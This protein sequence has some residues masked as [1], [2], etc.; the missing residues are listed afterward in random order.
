MKKLIE[1]L[2]IMVGM[3]ILIYILFPNIMRV[4]IGQYGFLFVLVV[5]I[6]IIINSIPKRRIP[7]NQHE[8]PV[9]QLEYPDDEPEY[10]YLLRDDFLSLAEQSFY[11]TLKH[12]CSDWALICPKVALGNLFYVRSSDPSDFRTYTNKIDRKHVDF[13]L[14]DPI[15]AKPLLGIELDDKSHQRSEVM[16]R[17][18]FVENVYRSAK[19]PLV[20]IPVKHSYSTAELESLLRQYISS[21]DFETPGQPLI[22]EN[23]E[24][25][26]HCPKCGNGMVLRTAKNGPNQGEQFWGCPDYPRCRGVRKYQA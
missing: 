6:V 9:D 4:V 2:A 22:I 5:I 14:C 8:Y 20:R 23:I 17:D 10:P 7:F 3:W 19:L 15:T 26:P 16:A 11:L 13:L 25:T 21:N 12:T 18:D 1:N 24:A